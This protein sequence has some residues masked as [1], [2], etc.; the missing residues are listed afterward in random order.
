[1]D[2]T[3]AIGDHIKARRLALELTQGD[4]AER[5]GVSKAM[6]C[7]VECGKKNPTIRLLGQLANGL[8]CGISDLLDL[9]ETPRFVSDR[10]GQ[11]RTLID[12]ETG[13]QRRV[14]SSAMLRRGIEIIE[15]T[16]PPGTDCSGFPPHYH[17]VYEAAVVVEGRVKMV[18]GSDEIEM[19]PGDSVTYAADVEH[20]AYNRAD[21]PARVIYI[22]DST[23]AR[24]TGAPAPGRGAKAPE[25]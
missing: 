19:G 7:D 2:D 6:I 10:R 8:G 4:L 3:A 18:I 17:G 22:I 9:D 11:Q 24:R 21:T 14:L 23:H 15:Y 12:P 13:V 25:D 1:M 16:Y 20:S 5:S